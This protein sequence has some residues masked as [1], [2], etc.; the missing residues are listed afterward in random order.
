MFD[1]GG[2]PS[3]LMKGCGPPPPPCRNGA[4]GGG[5][6]PEGM[7]GDTDGRYLIWFCFEE[8]RLPVRLT[9]GKGCWKKK[10]GLWGAM[11]VMGA[12]SQS[13]TRISGDFSHER[14]AKIGL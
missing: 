8:Q 5:G 2:G 1:G 14:R 11:L 6:G 4:G 13:R 9:S 3:T 10:K 7:V 12:Q